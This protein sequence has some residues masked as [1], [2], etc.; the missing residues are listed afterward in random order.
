LM[1]L[2]NKLSL[3]YEFEKWTMITFALVSATLV[4]GLVIMVGK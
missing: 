4:T 3:N 2:P 1:W